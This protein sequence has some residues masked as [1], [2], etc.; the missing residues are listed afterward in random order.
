MDQM[1]GAIMRAIELPGHSGEKGLGIALSVLEDAI[2]EAYDSDNARDGG[3]WD[4]ECSE[5]CTS[6]QFYIAL[7]AW[8]TRVPE[9]RDLAVDWLCAP[10]TYR[11]NRKALYLGL[12]EDLGGFFRDPRSE[13][14]FYVANVFSMQSSG[15]RAC[16]DALQALQKHLEMTDLNGLVILFDEFEDVLANINSVARQ[17]DAFTNL[18]FFFGGTRFT[19]KTFYAVTPDFV[20]R[21]KTR[22][23]QKGRDDFDCS[24]F[25]SLPTF[26]M[27]PLDFSDLDNLASRIWDAHR[28]AYGYAEKAKHGEDLMT[29]VRQAAR[30]P[31]QDRARQAIRSVVQFLD[32][33]VES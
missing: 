26:E 5:R 19:G 25:D 14:Q 21:C 20:D 16:W 33:L 8:C 32:G 6:P 4:G 9:A 27:S 13:R 15:Y 22:L 17:E 1:L 2:L 23:L 11:T 12:V 30:S 18:F 10:Y 31:V 7:R 29:I 3:L 24:R 28:D